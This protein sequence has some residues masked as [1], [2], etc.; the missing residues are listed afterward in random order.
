MNH[1]KRQSR[2]IHKFLTFDLGWLSFLLYFLFHPGGV[3]DI[4]CLEGLNNQG[5]STE[6]MDYSEN[7]ASMKCPMM[8]PIQKLVQLIWV[9]YLQ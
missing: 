9:Q 6:N 3:Y 8:V 5:H 2:L 7:F 1:L 4:P